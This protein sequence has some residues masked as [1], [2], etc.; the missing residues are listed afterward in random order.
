LRLL[1]QEGVK[2]RGNRALAD[3][4]SETKAS[5]DALLWKL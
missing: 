5:L 2:T 3:R 1:A 4:Q